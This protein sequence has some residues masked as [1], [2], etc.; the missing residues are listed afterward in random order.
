M[1][2][3]REDYIEPKSTEE[4]YN[5]LSINVDAYYIPLGTS[6]DGDFQIHFRRTVFGTIVFIT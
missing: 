4:I 6:D 2:V 1:I 3:Q 5:M